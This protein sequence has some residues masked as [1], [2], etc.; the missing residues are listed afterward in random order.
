MKYIIFGDAFTFPEGNAATNRVYT[1]A[2]GFVENDLETIVINFGND[3]DNEKSGTIEG[4]RFYQAFTP[5]SPHKNFFIRNWYKISK[6][7]NS[8]RLIKEIN[9]TGN[10]S[11]I[12]IYTKS[13][14]THLF[15][16][17]LSKYF[18]TKLI[19]ENSEHPLRYF[20]KGFYQ[21]YFGKLKLFIE[22]KTLDGILLISR[23]LVSFYLQKVNKHP[24]ILLVPSTVIPSRFDKP[25]SDTLP[26]EYIGYFGSIN[27]DR[28]KV[29]VLV[30]AFALLEKQFDN[31]HLVLGGLCLENDKN[32]LINLVESL[33]ISCK[34]HLLNYLSRE[35][36]SQ[37]FVDA[38]VLV[39]VRNNDIYTSASYPSKLTEYLATGNPVVSVNVGDISY[40]LKDGEN[41]FIIENLN[42]FELYEKLKYIFSDYSNAMQVGAK[43]KQLTYEIFNHS[44]QAHRIMDF[45]KS[46]SK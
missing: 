41:A 23:D 29:D 9:K 28:D 16:F 4:I 8:I 33:N 6:Y 12:I 46:L 18:R 17:F 43:G 24:F 31:L 39:L 5:S 19:A 38:K 32:L 45:I 11:A 35:E 7:Y 37:Y 15:V 2:K 1:Y 21:R 36:I 44:F 22:L 3:Y 27:F 42:T 40:Y 25:K 34:V 13:L 26:Y 14:L 30:H 20:T 10:I